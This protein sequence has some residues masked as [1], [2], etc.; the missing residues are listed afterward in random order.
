MHAIGR[1]LG[2]HWGTRRLVAC[3]IFIRYRSKPTLPYHMRMAWCSIFGEELL[4]IGW[5]WHRSHKPWIPWQFRFIPWIMLMI[6]LP[7]GSWWRF[8]GRERMKLRMGPYRWDLGE[9]QHQLEQGIRPWQQFKPCWPQWWVWGRTRVHWWTRIPPCTQ[10]S[11]WEHR[12]PWWRGQT[13]SN[14]RTGGEWSQVRMREWATH[15]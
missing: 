10:S 5:P 13:S 7:S 2:F 4:K 14:L 12:A 1:S 6:S 15:V 11:S 9:S 3:S 8:V